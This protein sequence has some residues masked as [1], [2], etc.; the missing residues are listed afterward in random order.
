MLGPEEILTTGPIF[1]TTVI[2]MNFPEFPLNLGILKIK[3][4]RPLR[5]CYIFIVFF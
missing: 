1:K 5:H 4:L 2:F 3:T